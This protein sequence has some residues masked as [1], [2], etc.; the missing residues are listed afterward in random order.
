MLLPIDQAAA[1]SR[2]GARVTT[3]LVIDDDDEVRSSLR[4][5]LEEAGYDVY[6]ARHGRE[7]VAACQEH[8]IDLVI[9]D[10]LMP[11][12]DG[13]G[14]PVVNGQFLAVGCQ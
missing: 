3:I 12:Q 6:E 1:P 8:A 9:T 10:I 7:G 2:E 4:T 11:E 5:L 14:P 13:L